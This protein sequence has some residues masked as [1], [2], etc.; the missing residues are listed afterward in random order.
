MPKT[1]YISD[2]DGTLLD[3]NAELSDFT[4]GALN[5]LIARGVHFTVASARTEYSAKFILERLDLR[6]PVCLSNGVTLYDTRGKRYLDTKYIDLGALSG[7]LRLAREAG[8]PPLVYTLSGSEM[9]VYYDPRSETDAMREF[10]ELRRARYGKVFTPTD[11]LYALS[12]G[13]MYLSAMGERGEIAPLAEELRKNPLLSVEFYRNTYTESTWLLEVFS[14]E[15]SKG[16]G[17][18]TLRRKYGFDRVVG[19]GDNLNDLPMFAVCDEAYATANAQDAVKA[20]A[21]AVIGANDADGAAR[22]LAAHA[23]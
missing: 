12:S 13:V 8:V 4:V 14:S 16:S 1:L 5:A 3:N 10:R 6:L 17:V 22:W 20:A 15:A 19:F 7:A 2:L 21:T 18:E 23:T 9:R 11:N